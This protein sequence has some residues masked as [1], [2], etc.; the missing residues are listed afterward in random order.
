M[1]PWS[2]ALSCLL[3]SGVMLV[4]LARTLRGPNDWTEAHWLLDYRFG[5]IKRGLPGEILRWIAGLTGMALDEAT[6]SGVSFA[7]TALCCAALGFVAFRILHANHFAPAVVAA[8]AA[9]LCSPFV[10]LTGHLVGYYEHLVLPLA[11]GSVWLVLRGRPWAG[12]ALIAVTPFMHEIALVLVFPVF[13]FAWLARA[14]DPLP[15]RKPPSPRPPSPW[16]LVLPLL[17][18]LVMAAVILSPP[19]FF[20]PRFN[21]HLKAFPFVGGGFEQNTSVMLVMPSSDAFLLLRGRLGERAAQAGLYGVVLP[22]L[23][24][25]VLV[26]VQRLRAPT[27][28]L[29]ALLA[30]AVVL[31]PQALHLIA[32]DLER[33][34]T[35]S[36]VTALLLV[37]VLAET[38][39]AAAAAVPGLLPLS[40]LATGA[41]FL[42]ATPL[43]DHQVDR[44]A[45]IVRALAGAAVVLLLLANAAAADNTPWR[46][47]FR[48]R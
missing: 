16:P 19:A 21:E 46:E 34:A 33:I 23:M 26:V 24:V 36:L 30:A 13:A 1:R 6:I 38:R 37:W 35:W 10:V 22:T 18:A 8:I 40:L 11:I 7:A 9:F 12:A 5:P 44:I 45:P 20:V 17:T 4:T 31:L 27:L 3:L 41:N 29:Q 32:W 39:P 42:L 25:L 43:L 48:W 28:S 15:D 2:R 14:A 47:R